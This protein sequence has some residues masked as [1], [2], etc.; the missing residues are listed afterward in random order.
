VRALDSLSM[1]YRDSLAYVVY[2][3][4]EMHPELESKAGKARTEW[5]GVVPHLAPLAFFDGNVRSPQIPIPDSFYPIYRNMIDG[6]RAQQTFLEMTIDS[7]TTGIEPALLHL[8]IR[9]TPTDSSVDTMTTL[10]LVAIVYED[11]VPYYSMLRGDT[12]F[13][14]MTVRQVIGDSFGI[15]IRLKFGQNFDTLLTTPV[16]DY[17]IDRVGV[18]VSVQNYLNRAVYQSVIKRKLKN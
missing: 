5:Y 18:V 15:P 10:R 8:G 12:V 13:S 2:Y 7:S 3:L 9:I 1:T 6:A 11:G 16:S 4:S 14:P 17:N